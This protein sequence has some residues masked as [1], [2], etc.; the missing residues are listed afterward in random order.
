MNFLDRLWQNRN[1][2]RAAKFRWHTQRIPHPETN[3][4]KGTND[5]DVQ[6][7]PCLY[8][9]FNEP[10]NITYPCLNLYLKFILQI[11]LPVA[12]RSTFFPAVFTLLFIVRHKIIFTR[13]MFIRKYIISYTTTT[14]LNGSSFWLFF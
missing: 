13:E 11:V 6:P 4:G 1:S 3:V 8:I 5:K 2:C 14:L 7:D 10:K 9:T 12:S